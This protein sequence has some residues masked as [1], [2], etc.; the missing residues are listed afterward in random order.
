MR[1][2]STLEAMDAVQQTGAQMETILDNHGKVKMYSPSYGEGVKVDFVGETKLRSAY[3][4]A[5]P[6][7]MNAKWTL[8][9]TPVPAWEAV[10]AYCEGKNVYY[11]NPEGNRFYLASTFNV[12]VERFGN[13]IWYIDDGEV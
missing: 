4:V 12:G 5:S 6:D 1:E 10:K 8:V 9:R 7:I 3:L 13:G 2:H 11:E